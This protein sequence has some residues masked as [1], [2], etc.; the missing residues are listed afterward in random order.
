MLSFVID[1]STL[2]FAPCLFEN[3]NRKSYLEKEQ[4]E[5]LAIGWQTD[6]QDL[7]KCIKK[8]ACLLHYLMMFGTK[9]Q[10]LRK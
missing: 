4:L 9:I 7:P 3:W 8:M 1:I 10:I 2:F 5:G 6:R